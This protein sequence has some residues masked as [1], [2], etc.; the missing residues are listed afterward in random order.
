MVG[1]VRSL[2][3]LRGLYVLALVVGD[4][5][6]LRLAFVLAY[7]MRMLGEPNGGLPGDPPTSYDDMAVVCVVVIVLVFALRRLYIPRRGF[8]R[9][10]LLYQITA[11]VALG[12][13][14]A[15]ATAL[16]I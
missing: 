8:G 5:V 6:A 3:G 15:L 16:F 10:D 13:L 7:R 14:A 9:V 2:S 11:A 1:V 4:L 12:W